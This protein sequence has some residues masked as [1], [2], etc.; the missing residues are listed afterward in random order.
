M[1]GSDTTPAT[2]GIVLIAMSAMINLT[3]IFACVGLYRAQRRIKDR[4]TFKNIIY[5]TFTTILTVGSVAFFVLDTVY[6]GQV[7]ESYLA[8]IALNLARMMSK[9]SIGLS[10]WPLVA[11]SS[12]WR[13][14]F[15]VQVL[16]LAVVYFVYSYIA[17][18]LWIP[19]AFVYVLGFLPSP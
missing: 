11:E 18:V 15:L 6:R 16:V 17:F 2:Q 7:G 13:A 9:L 14:F 12:E 4:S 5:F 3:A 19:A 10:M 8:W 1:P